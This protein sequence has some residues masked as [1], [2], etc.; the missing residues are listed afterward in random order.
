MS[1]QSALKA[2]SP[3][4]HMLFMT[5]NT[6]FP[7][8]LRTP[9]KRLRVS[10][11]SIYLCRWSSPWSESVYWSQ[12]FLLP[13]SER[14]APVPNIWFEGEECKIDWSGIHG[15][16][17]RL[18]KARPW[19]VEAIF[20]SPW[21]MILLYHTIPAPAM[22]TTLSNFLHK[23]HQAILFLQTRAAILMHQ[24]FSRVRGQIRHALCQQLFQHADR[25]MGESRTRGHERSRGTLWR[26]MALLASW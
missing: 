19:R 16:E 22:G 9:S 21:S 6:I 20:S 1:D 5:A 2:V 24:A 11:C 13:C 18:R 8:T 25:R 15:P 17:T 4:C 14:P 3:S 7:Q 26:D 12:P 23:I 10:Q